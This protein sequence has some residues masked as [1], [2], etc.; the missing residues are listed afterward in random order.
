MIHGVG[1]LWHSSAG[2]GVSFALVLWQATGRY[3]GVSGLGAGLAE[4]RGPGLLIALCVTWGRPGWYVVGA[5]F[6][7]AGL[8]APPAVRWAQRRQRAPRTRLAPAG[9]APAA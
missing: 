3:L 5:V 6:A 7:L 4:A 9:R 1:G 2:F 8:A